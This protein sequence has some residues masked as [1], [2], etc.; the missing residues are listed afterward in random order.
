ME[1]KYLVIAMVNGITYL[2]KVLAESTGGAEHKVLDLGY[3]GKHEYGVEGC[4]AYDSALMKTDCFRYEALEAEPIELDRLKIIIEKR[5]ECIR[6]RDAAED[7][8]CDIEKELRQLTERIELMKAEQ[9]EV[10]EF[11]NS[12]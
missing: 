4:T 7:R 1:Q 8:L 9:N 3:C 2:T 12:L 11:M 5:N 10:L 6:Q